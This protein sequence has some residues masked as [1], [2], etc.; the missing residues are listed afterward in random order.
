M[1]QTRVSFV[2]G[3]I[4]LYA[5]IFFAELV[6]AISTAIAED[7]PDVLFGISVER[8]GSTIG[9]QTPATS[10]NYNGTSL[11]GEAEVERNVSGSTSSNGLSMQLGCAIGGV[12]SL[13]NP[14]DKQKVNVYVRGTATS[15]I[16]ISG[17]GS[18][19]VTSDGVPRASASIS[20]PWNGTAI[21]AEKPTGS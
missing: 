13:C 17:S 3:K 10:W 19:S 21:E 2:I 5:V 18:A 15:T 9:S 4:A 1:V 20:P 16:T 7:V 14:W 11:C 8:N 12:T 6:L